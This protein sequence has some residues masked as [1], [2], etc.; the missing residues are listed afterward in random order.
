MGHTNVE[1][2]LPEEMLRI[3]Q[4]ESEC[5]NS[6]LQYVTYSKYGN[7]LHTVDSTNQR[8]RVSIET[9]SSAFFFQVLL[10]FASLQI[11]WISLKYKPHSLRNPKSPSLYVCLSLPYSFCLSSLSSVHY[12]PLIIRMV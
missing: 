8:L 10:Y 4:R 11:K 3:K 7:T 12:S 1:D 9:T 2:L 6:H 5:N